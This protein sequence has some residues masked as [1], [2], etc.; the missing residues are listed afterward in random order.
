MIKFKS[1]TNYF[2]PKG[3]ISIDVTHIVAN[4]SGW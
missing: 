1:I 4:N 2:I 3:K